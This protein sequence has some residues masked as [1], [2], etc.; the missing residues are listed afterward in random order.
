MSIQ[1]LNSQ[2]SSTQEWSSKRWSHAKWQLLQSVHQNAAI[3]DWSADGIHLL[4]NKGEIIYNSQGQIHVCK[5]SISKF[6]ASLLS[7]K[8][9]FLSTQG[10]IVSIFVWLV[11]TTAGLLVV[12]GVYP[13]WADG[14]TLGE[15]T[16]YAMFMRVGWSLALSWVTFACTKGYGSSINSFLSWGPFTVLGRLTFF[17]YLIHFEIIPILMWSTTYSYELNCSQIVSDNSLLLFFSILTLV[18]VF[19]HSFIL[20][21]WW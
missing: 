3:P 12:I 1:L 6:C 2:S 5:D 14:Y 19:S 16:F 13:M 11:A 18:S 10:T 17:S 20:E 9:K 7:L 4:Q 15:S 21:C 8:S